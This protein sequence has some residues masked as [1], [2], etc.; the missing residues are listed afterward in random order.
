MIILARRDRSV[1]TGDAQTVEM[2][3]IAQVVVS[4][5]M[6][7][8]NAVPPGTVLTNMPPY[9]MRFMVNAKNVCLITSVNSSMDFWL[10]NASIALV[11]HVHHL[12]VPALTQPIAQI[13]MEDIL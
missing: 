7:Y 10:R 3:R 11:L 9:V 12:A 5:T 4:V 13:V 2:T 6:E 8:A 1:T